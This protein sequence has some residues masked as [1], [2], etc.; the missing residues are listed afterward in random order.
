M[1]GGGGDTEIKE[2]EQE[3]ELA[4]IATEEWQ[5]YQDTFVPLEN[6][7]IED[8]TQ[9]PAADKERI[10][11][12][13]AGRVGSQ[14]DQAQA[15]IDDKA[16]AAGTNVNSGMFKRQL[17]RGGD[18]GEAVARGN[19]GVDAKKTGELMG[20][21]QTGRGQQASAQASLAD[22]ANQSV[23][24][25]MQSST[26]KYINSRETGNLVGTGAGMLTR[27]FIGEDD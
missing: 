3:K 12:I 5:R 4:R 25:A 23:Q 9:D 19:V 21:I 20:A 13:T 24:D 26:N 7:W 10:A 2:T 16:L 6:E 1:G 11:G 27:K 18:V 8:V 14:Y 22:V 15:E 17:N